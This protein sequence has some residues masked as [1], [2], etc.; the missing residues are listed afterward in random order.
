MFCFCTETQEENYNLLSNWY[1]QGL[2]SNLVLE[3]SYILFHL[4]H[5]ILITILGQ[6]Y[7]SHSID[8]NLNFSE[9]K[10]LL[11]VIKPVSTHSHIFSIL[12][13]WVF[14][15]KFYRYRTYTHTHIRHPCFFSEQ[16]FLLVEMT[17]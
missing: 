6:R 5:L 17:L 9:V 10:K 16:Q 11:K 7:Y 12:L 15:N 1:M 3:S 2:S 14:T 8:K 4:F 13:H